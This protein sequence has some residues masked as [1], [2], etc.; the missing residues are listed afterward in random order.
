MPLDLLSYFVSI[1]DYQGNQI[2]DKIVS[3]KYK[4]DEAGD[5]ICEITIESDK[6]DLPDNPAYAQ[7]KRL[8]VKWGWLNGKVAKQRTVWIW[9][10]KDEYESDGNC[11]LHLI[12]HDLFALAKM[13]S[14][15]NKNLTQVKRGVPIVFST[16]VLGNL[17]LDVDG[18]NT[19]LADLLKESQINLHG[20]KGKDFG[21]GNTIVSY[22]NGNQSTFFGL[23]NYLDR[24][25]GGPYVIDSR[26]DRVLIRTRNFQARAKFTYSYKQENGQL[27]SFTPETKNRH[28]KKNAEKISITTWDHDSK[29][30]ATFSSQS[31][32]HTDIVLANGKTLDLSQLS[33]DLADL[34]KPKP[35]F[36]TQAINKVISHNGHIYTS[37]EIHSELEK[38]RY[39]EPPNPNSLLGKIAI[40]SKN[41]NVRD[42]NPTND[43]SE[44]EVADK[45]IISRGSMS[46]GTKVVKIFLGDKTGVD[47]GTHTTVARD[48]VA[49]A[50]KTYALVNDDE[51]SSRNLLSNDD[52]IKAKGFAENLR[53][54]AE[55][56]MH[57]AKM[58]LI[59]EPELEVA[60]I[61]T[62]K[63]VALKDSGN[64]YTKECEHKI[65]H[66][67]YFTTIEKA[68][69]HGTTR[70]KPNKGGSTDLSGKLLPL[71]KNF[72]DIKPGD[73]QVDNGVIVNISEG[74]ISNSKTK[75]KI[76]TSTKASNK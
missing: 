64:Y 56:E 48:A 24:L 58:E 6:V 19:E 60:D 44:A 71:T 3:F 65:D 36:S 35:Q 42:S 54:N 46:D 21:K 1:L 32:K 30:A 33:K 12:C 76:I 28:K 43:L 16:S 55:L 73:F 70:T 74:K 8:K 17:A 22:F 40:I 38:P 68:F 75:T 39:K 59:G 11:K 61:I 20:V 66:Q 45:L 23:R 5:D 13:D 52:Y 26:D 2:R 14:V 69:R 34:N 63:N 29:E 53:K 10:T 4:F 67:G 41:I 18:G 50:S 47:R 7:G 49:M 25:P 15:A 9:D 37:E 51:S 31:G 72:G 27:I 57:P 62:I